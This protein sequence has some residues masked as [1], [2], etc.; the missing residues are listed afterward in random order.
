M[1]VSTLV[2]TNIVTLEKGCDRPFRSKDDSYLNIVG[3]I[4]IYT[5]RRDIVQRSLNAP[6]LL[7]VEPF[8]ELY[9][10]SRTG[11]RTLSD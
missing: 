2:R 5:H 4:D 9:H 8:G 11:N 7:K 10:S 6:R 1:K 3:N